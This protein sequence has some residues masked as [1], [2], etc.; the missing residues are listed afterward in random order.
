MASITTL[1]VS[2]RIKGS[3]VI[4]FSQASTK[5]SE[6]S[7][8]KIQKLMSHPLEP[9]KLLLLLFHDDTG[10]ALLPEEH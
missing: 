4:P 9:E 5:S 6:K 2:L 8:Y 10:S 3:E 7:F 1:I